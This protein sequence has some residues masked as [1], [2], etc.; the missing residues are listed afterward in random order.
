MAVCEEQA[1]LDNRAAYTSPMRVERAFNIPGWMLPTELVWLAYQAQKYRHIVEIGSYLGRSTRALADNTQGWVLAV[2]DFGGP[3][4]V[5]VTD[6]KDIYASFLRNIEGVED[7][8][9][10]CREDFDKVNPAEHDPPFDMIFIDGEH[11]YASVRRDIEKWQPYLSPGGILCGH[12][13][14]PRYKGLVQA[15]FE[16]FEKSV[17]SIPGTEIWVVYQ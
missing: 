4:D 3:R 14:H 8:V 17:M 16:L 5:E 11:N 13:F 7:K 1:I 9:H 2:D 15:I 6:R 12:D 10:I